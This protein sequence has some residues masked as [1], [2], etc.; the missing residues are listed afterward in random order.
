MSLSIK[1]KAI[2]KAV[3][4]VTTIA[5]VVCMSGVASFSVTSLAIADVVD[6]AL[7][8]SNTT[9]PDGTPSLSSLD[10]YIVKL[11]GTK[12]FK[13]L[14]LNPTVF[15][16]Y[17]H[18]NWGD[19]QTVSQ[20]VMDEYTTSALV[21]VDTDP[22]EKVYALAP[23]NDTG[24]KSWVNVTA[25]EFLG[26]AGSEDGDSI[27]TINSTDAGSY[28]ATGNVTTVAQLET[29]YSAGT[30][31]AASEAGTGL[32]VALA[33]DTPGST[34][35]PTGAAMVEFTKVNFIAASDGDVTVKNLVVKRIGVGS[36]ASLGGV[37]I[38]DGDTRLTN[39]RTISSTT[40]KATFNGINVVISAG[41]TK[42]LSIR[43]SVAT[44]TGNHGFSVDSVSDI[45]TDGAAVSGSF[46]ISGNTMTFSTVAAGA[47]T[48]TLQS[49]AN[50]TLKVG[51]KQ[52]EVAEIKIEETSGNEDI[53]LTSITFTNDGSADAGDLKNF[54]LY[55]GTDL[56]AT[57]ESSSSDRATMVFDTPF[58]ITK[59]TNKIFSLKADIMGGVGA[60]SIVYDID[61]L[62]DVVAAGATYGYGVG[63]TAGGS[64][65]SITVEAG[66]LTIEV[67]GP[68]AY[69]V[70]NDADDVVLA[71]LTITTGG[72]EDVEIKN[73]YAY[74]D[75]TEV[76]GT[77]LDDGIENVQ[78]VNVDTGDIYDV[79]ADDL[80]DN[81]D[82]YFKITNFTVPAGESKWEVQADMISTVVASGD[83]LKFAMWAGADVADV[84]EMTS[85]KKGVEAENQAGKALDDIKPGAAISGNNI[86][87]ATASLA[88][89]K[90]TL[91]NGTAVARTEGVKLN[92]F[93]VEAGNAEAIKITQVA[94]E[95][96]AGDYLDAS[97]YSLYVEGVTDPIEEGVSAVDA[98]TD[99]VT[100][101]SITGGGY[102][103]PAG[104]TKT[105]YITGDIASS[106]L[107]A[108]MRLDLTADGITAE[109][110]DGDALA[111]A[112]I[113]GNDSAI[114][115]RTVTLSTKGSI[116][117]T[118]DSS[119]PDNAHILLSGTSDNEVLKVK[120]D[121][122]DEDIM[123][124]TLKFRNT[125]AANKT[126]VQAT[127]TV[128]T[129]LVLTAAAYGPSGNDLSF[130][131]TLATAAQSIV[132]SKS[133]TVITA[134]VSDP[135]ADAVT[136]LDVAEA[137]AMTASGNTG[138]NTVAVTITNDVSDY[139]TATAGAATVA[140]AVTATSLAGGVGYSEVE[141]ASPSTMTL[142]TLANSAVNDYYLLT[143]NNVLAEAVCFYF[144]VAG[145]ITTDGA[146]AAACQNAD[147][148]AGG[149][150]VN[151]ST[152]TTNADVAALFH[153]AIV[154]VGDELLVNSFDNEDGTLTLRLDATATDSTMAV[155]ATYWDEGV[156]HANGLLTAVT[157]KSTERSMLK[158]GLYQNDVLVKED[159]TSSDA[160]YFIFSGLDTLATP[161]I[162]E[163]DT[164]SI[165]TVKVDSASVG[166]GP[167]DTATTGD[168][169]KLEL[170]NVTATTDTFVEALGNSSQNSLV[171]GD[172]TVTS[173]ASQNQNLYASKVIA[174]DSG[175]QASTLSSGQ[176]EALKF[177]LTPTTND[178]KV[179]QFTGLNIT[180]DL[181]DNTGGDLGIQDSGSTYAIEVYSG[182]TRVGYYSST[183]LDKV[184]GLKT[185]TIT[186]NDISSAG[187]TFVVKV[188]AVA[189]A[190]D[191]S[192]TASVAINGTV[193]AD[194]ITWTDYS[195]GSSVQW[196]D[197]GEGSSITSI[198]NTISK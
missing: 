4:V 50:T 8:K 46:P 98:A 105:L 126:A 179:A 15:N 138:T 9:N 29:F 122:S 102:T 81:S 139:L 80:L 11:V 7:I 182:S 115:G 2:K 21:R 22:D 136:T 87:I 78:L 82:F 42:A 97:N 96:G 183:T 74:V 64:T 119:S 88:V 73:L 192:L 181:T 40:D 32:T 84:T 112:A 117:F 175:S 83:I 99:T 45:T 52:Q 193:G 18:L 94:A 197:L 155:D 141:G 12:K 71:N 132:V 27:Y 57:L 120:A 6:G 135:A 170:Q 177:T 167:N 34:T 113:S 24:K 137:L 14:V 152:A 79:T 143:D 5:T 125:G 30:L 31:P 142:P 104:E 41:E 180:V 198:S 77:D 55:R 123:I 158:V 195:G 25:A 145:T 26:V 184:S 157:S 3:S 93:T 153:A 106:G 92:E 159:T 131:L 61:D 47:L 168:V 48:Y 38:Y 37:Y 173:V 166:T 1:K 147:G 118:V 28:V 110:T 156:T 151:I 53:N 62:T 75:A 165:F 86:T 60:A 43:S 161:V 65:S 16:S 186:A 191:D 129:D 146:T 54:N 59:S 70:V 134:A 190:A 176:K 95:L 58:A 121:A 20:S 140:T 114:T 23:E 89:A 160:G 163:K 189:V 67:D 172:I 103:V 90:V 13:R 107:T 150:E 116:A 169:I 44:G 144:D 17:G 154:G 130:V 35:V 185:L 188:Y 91:Q 109:D 124:K 56:V 162:V 164:D 51:E 111:D 178:N 108:T 128:S 36:S 69:E 39:A 63:V 187:E 19:I 72:D 127:A 133:G 100:F 194:D 149:V 85:L 148:V 10:V 196:I 171:F 174:T 68:A 49:V 66:E 101:N 33:S 76:A